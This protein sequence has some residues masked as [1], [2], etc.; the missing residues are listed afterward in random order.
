MGA[1]PIY[2]AMKK[3]SFIIVCTSIFFGAW[4]ERKAQS[5]PWYS[6]VDLMD[7]ISVRYQGPNPHLRDGN[8][9]EASTVSPFGTSSLQQ[10][11]SIITKDDNFGM[12]LHLRHKIEYDHYIVGA[13]QD[14]TGDHFSHFSAQWNLN[15]S[16]ERKYSASG[17]LKL[18]YLRDFF[19]TTNQWADVRKSEYWYNAQ[20]QDTTSTFHM[21]ES[22]SGRLLIGEKRNYFYDAKGVET[23]F[24]LFIS[25]NGQWNRLLKEDYTYDVKQQLST[26]NR[27]KWN[28]TDQVWQNNVKFSYQY[29]SVGNQTESVEQRWINGQWAN[30]LKTANTFDIFGNQVESVIQQWF[31]SGWGN[32]QKISQSIGANNYPDTTIVYDWWYS[33]M[34]KIRKDQHPI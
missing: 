13:S 12:G 2:L 34:D 3:A 17:L 1:K 16:T 14:Y 11:D 27:L 23:S 30:Y 33:K 31:S 25:E 18:S 28:D 5:S 7:S 15:G 26:L 6:P 8:V 29:D 21:W 4:G 22:R 32:L 24:I 10:L 9:K 19:S 20:G